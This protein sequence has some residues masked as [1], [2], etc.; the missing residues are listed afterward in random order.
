MVSVVVARS[1]GRVVIVSRRVGE[2]THVLRWCLAIIPL[3]HLSLKSM[4]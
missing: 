1:V 4:V 3:A 2:I